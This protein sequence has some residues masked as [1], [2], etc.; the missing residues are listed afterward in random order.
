MKMHTC[1]RW[2]DLAAVRDLIGALSMVHDTFVA[3]PMR[4]I[5]I[6]ENRVCVCVSVSVRLFAFI[7]PDD[8]NGTI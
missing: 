3:M 2:M 6:N 4:R 8:S 7:A 5:I 1:G